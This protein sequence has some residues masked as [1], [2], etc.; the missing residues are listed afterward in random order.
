MLEQDII[1]AYYYQAGQLEAALQYDKTLKEAERVLNT[2][3]EYERVL[4]GEKV[5]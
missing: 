4:K 5:K 3:G 2:P 1:S